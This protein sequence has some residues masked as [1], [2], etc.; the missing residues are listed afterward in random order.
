[1]VVLVH[2]NSCPVCRSQG[3]EAQKSA[4]VNCQRSR[5]KS[6]PDYR[7]RRSAARPILRPI[8]VAYSETTVVR[9][10]RRTGFQPVDRRCGNKSPAEMIRGWR[11]IHKRRTPLLVQELPLGL[12]SSSRFSPVGAAAA[13]NFA[14]DCTCRHAGASVDGRDVGA[15]SGREPLRTPAVA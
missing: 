12:V 13:R 2:S 6:L 15:I 7:C 5:R 3:V 8:T 10:D 1:L 9:Q 14:Q 11:Q 4:E